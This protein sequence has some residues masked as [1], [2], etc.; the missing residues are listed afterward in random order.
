MAIDLVSSAYIFLDC[1]VAV[2]SMDLSSVVAV[3]VERKDMRSVLSIAESC[4]LLEY[5]M[6]SSVSAKRTIGPGGGKT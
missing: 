6:Q 2:I 4:V 3:V 1:C 5:S